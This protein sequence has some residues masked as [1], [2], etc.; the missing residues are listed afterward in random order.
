VSDPTAPGDSGV[1]PLG[2]S[3]PLQL[4][5]AVQ[6]EAFVEDQV[7]VV[8]CPSVIEL[9]PKDMTGVPG[10]GTSTSSVTEFA[11]DVPNVFAQVSV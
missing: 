9:E 4:P 8:D 6:P 1:L 7:K 10:G 5:E 11:P 3:A 2:F